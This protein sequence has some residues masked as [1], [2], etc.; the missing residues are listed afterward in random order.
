MWTR[1][2]LSL[3][4]EEKKDR[5]TFVVAFACDSFTRYAIAHISGN[6]HSAIK[7]YTQSF[8]ADLRAIN[9]RPIY[10]MIFLTFILLSILIVNK[11]YKTNVEMYTV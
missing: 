9:E 7:I 8:I 1:K 6:N 5:F 11:G 3:A 2:N 10:Y 4:L